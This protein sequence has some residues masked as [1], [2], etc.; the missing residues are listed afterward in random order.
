M[1][2]VYT[3]E[4]DFSSR[5]WQNQPYNYGSSYN[6]PVTNIEYVT[7]LE[8]AIMRTNVR[9][10][11]KVYFKQ[12]GGVF[13]RVKMD[14]DGRKSWAEFPY[15]VPN[16]DTSRPVMISD[17]QPIFDRLEKLEKSMPVEVVNNVNTNGQGNV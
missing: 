3:G 10:S 2:N 8:E 14:M 1:N 7:S 13:Y 6:V 12:D 17:L 11:D 5:G 16:V 9:G 4:N 15:S